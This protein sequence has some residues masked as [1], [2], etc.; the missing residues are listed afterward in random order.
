MMMDVKSAAAYACV[1]E[2]VLRGWLKDGLPHFRV[3]AKGKRGHY[4]IAREDLDAWLASFK[5]TKKEPEPVKAPAR[6]PQV[7]SHLKIS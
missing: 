5:V 4:R 6:L 1:S 7:F 2:T 3:G